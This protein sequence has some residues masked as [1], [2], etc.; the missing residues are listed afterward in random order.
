MGISAIRPVQSQFPIQP[1]EPRRRTEK[2]SFTNRN[3][4][5][6]TVSISDE[7]LALSQMARSGDAVKTA[8]SEGAQ[9][10]EALPDWFA[11]MLPASVLSSSKGLPGV[12]EVLN[13]SGFNSMGLS[14]EDQRYC[15]ELGRKFSEVLSAHGI[16]TTDE[17]R[18]SVSGNSSFGKIFQQELLR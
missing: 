9:A 17:Y 12:R 6:D 14:E 1:V 16:T 2:T 4:G 15:E 13:G 18:E 10:A 8:S 11:G 3:T 5:P 7:A